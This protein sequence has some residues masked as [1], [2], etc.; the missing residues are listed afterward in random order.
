MIAPTSF[1]LVAAELRR[2]LAE[3]ISGLDE[4]QISISHPGDIKPDKAANLLNLFFY[5]VEFAGYPADGNCLD[6]FGYRM[7]CLITAFGCEDVITAG[8]GPPQK[9]STGEN[10][11]RLLGEVVR[12]L[13]QKSLIRIDDG[14]AA[15]H[16][17]PLFYPLSLDDLNRIW[18]TQGDT[19]YRLSVAYEFGLV[20][21][22]LAQP[23]R[24]GP[25][26]GSVGAA[27]RP[28]VRRPEPVPE[29]AAHPL[30]VPRVEL[31]IGRADWSPHVCFLVEGGNGSK[32]SLA[33]VLY[34]PLSSEQRDF[35]ILLAGAPGAKISLF[36]EVWD[37][38]GG[39]WSR[40]EAD[41]N[42][43]EATIPDGS[44]ANPPWP[45][46]VIDPLE[47]DDRLRQTVK[48]PSA[49]LSPGPAARQAVL[50]PCRAW[51]RQDPPR[52]VAELP[53]R[54]NPLLVV[55]T[56]GWES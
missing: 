1:S 7:H 17:H 8:D 39:Q 23:P 2:V 44:R 15:L 55:P 20:F 53:L 40:P 26:I 14:E 49:L 9:L 37:S 27:V 5:R 25:L 12:V 31:N 34:L 32:K 45:T 24:P 54:G 11:L 21:V 48:L 46:H 50:Y 4:S 42:T 29:V 52:S 41:G 13:Q 22:P 10:E 43:P 18:S 56:T 16:L 47:V 28:E 3:E 6:S 51:E 35:T 33:Y 38:A 36:W 19:F 30:R